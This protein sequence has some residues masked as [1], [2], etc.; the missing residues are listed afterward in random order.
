[1]NYKQ[2]T[3]GLGVLKVFAIKEPTS[4]IIKKIQRSGGFQEKTGTRLVVFLGGYLSR[5]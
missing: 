5:F 3:F 2:R 4:P 1:M